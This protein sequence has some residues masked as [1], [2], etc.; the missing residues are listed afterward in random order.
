MSGLWKLHSIKTTPR[1]KQVQTLAPKMSNWVGVDF[2]N[3]TSFFLF[4]SNMLKPLL[5]EVVNGFMTIVTFISQN[6]HMCQSLFIYDKNG[7]DQFYFK[8]Y[9]VRFG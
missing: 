6:T 4:Q 1:V 2:A 3:E 7:L 5:S 9:F 8:L